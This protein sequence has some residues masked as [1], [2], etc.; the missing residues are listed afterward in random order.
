MSQWENGRPIFDSLPEKGYRDNEVADALTSWVDQELSEKAALLQNFYKQLDPALCDSDK[1]DFLA[2][3]NGL[4]GNF[5]DSAWSDEVKRQLIANAH[6]VLWDKRGTATALRFV[7]DTHKIKYHLWLDGSS[8]M[9]FKMPT[10]MA[11]PKLRFFIRLPITYPRHSKE[12][13]EALRTARNFAPAIVGYRV[14]HEYFRCGF[15]K[16]GE[17]MFK[18]GSFNKTL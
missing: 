15:S 12:W 7:L 3:L 17:P 9:A 14:C 2:Y 6:P 4:S 1:L 5:W 8:T 13:N 18:S 11:D 16:V 10:K